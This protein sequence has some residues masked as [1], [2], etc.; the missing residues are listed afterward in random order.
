MFN[1]NNTLKT[2]RTDYQKGFLTEETVLENPFHQFEAWLSEAFDTGNDYANA[3][4][5]S[6]VDAHQMPDSRVVLLRNIS[7]GGLTFYTNYKSKKA[8]DIKTNHNASILFFWPD[9]ERQVRIEGAIEVLP[10]K[11][12]DDYFESRPFESK[13]GAWVSHQS[14]VLKSLA[15]LETSYEHELQKYAGKKVPRPAH[16]GGYVLVPQKFEFW[17]GR[18][19]RLHD[20]IQYRKASET[21]WTIERLMP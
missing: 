21:K 10:V 20:R 12:S 18:A 3:M 11:E 19:S 2:V 6:T 13:V 17:Q 8:S 1:A 15:D 4:V 9:M 14:Q 5:L 7:Y 16:W